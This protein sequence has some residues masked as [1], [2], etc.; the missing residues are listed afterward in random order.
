MGATNIKLGPCVV[1][2][3]SVDLGLTLGGV[4]VEVTTSTKEINVDQFGE[5]PVEDIIIG[6][7]CMVKVPL[8]ET[9]IDNLVAIMPGATKIVDGT[10]ATTIKVEVKT[11]VGLSLLNLAQ[12]LV[13]KPKEAIDDSENFTIPLAMAPGAMS[14]AYKI[15]EERIF[16]AEFKAYPD[17]NGVIYIF[18]DETAVAA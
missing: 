2:F 16:M 5:T 14:F 4:E 6:R 3:N 7:V 9:T 11:G 13:L 10:T 18:G 8:A 1:T 17:A 12:K 15:D